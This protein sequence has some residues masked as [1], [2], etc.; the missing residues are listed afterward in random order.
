[1]LLGFSEGRI[2]DKSNSGIP[3]ELG[4]DYLTHSFIA[5][6]TPG[7]PQVDMSPMR[8]RGQLH[9]CPSGAAGVGMGPGDQF[10]KYKWCAH[11]ELGSRKRSIKTWSQSV[12]LTLYQMY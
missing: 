10:L 11:W 5:D 4:Q 1:M 2:L 3:I 6:A 7:R 9:L 8:L 12:V